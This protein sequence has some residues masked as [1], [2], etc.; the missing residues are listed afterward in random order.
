[1]LDWMMFLETLDSMVVTEG[2]VA[3]EA[4]FELPVE[5]ETGDEY[6]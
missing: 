2:M 5:E 4:I 6:V 1:M 3:L